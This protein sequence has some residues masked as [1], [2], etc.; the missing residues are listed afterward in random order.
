MTR[1]GE[2]TSQKRD[3]CETRRAKMKF[4]MV[5]RAKVKRRE[6]T[7]RTTVISP[8]LMGQAS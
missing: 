5:K 6:M 8:G 2:A 3:E 4:E 1:K 7:L